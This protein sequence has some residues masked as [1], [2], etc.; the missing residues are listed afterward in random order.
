MP[1]GSF[2][3]DETGRKIAFLS[4]GIGITPIRSMCKY[5]IDTNLPVD[6]VLL[7]GNNTAGDI[8]FRDDFDNMASFSSNLRVIYTLTAAEAD[9]NWPGKRGYIDAG[10]IEQEIPDY[11]QRLF[12]VCGPPRMVETLVNVLKNDLRI[13]AGS[14]KLE[15]FSGY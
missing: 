8:I 5:A 12:Y 1:L 2:T 7:Y 13:G 3:L 9:K 10:M 11:K 15:N 14:I 6:V 4:G